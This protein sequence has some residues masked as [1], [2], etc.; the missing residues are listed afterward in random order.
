MSYP[1]WKK[2]HLTKAT[3]EK[4]KL[5][6]DSSYLWAQHDKNLLEK[7]SDEVLA[8]TTASTTSAKSP[9]MPSSANDVNNNKNN[10]HPLMSNVCCQDVEDV[11]VV[12]A[13]PKSSSARLDDAKAT[14]TATP[15]NSKARQAPKFVPPP[16]PT[17]EKLASFSLGILT[18]SDRAS[19]GQYE[20]G[21]LS[22]PAVR[23]SVL[24]FIGGGSETE[25]KTTNSKETQLDPTNIYMSI[26][27]DDINAIQ[28]QLRAW[29]SS[30][31]EDNSAKAL[32][33][34]FTTGG[35]GFSARD[36]TPEATVGVVDYTCEGLVTFCTMECASVQPLA[37]LSRGTAGI[38][39]KTMIVNLPGNPK[40]VQEI[41][42][43][44]LPLCLHVVAD[45]K[46][47]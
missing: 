25:E 12:A 28:D 15:A 7:R 44:L 39:N 13:A 5:Y 26:V 33:L 31:S 3:D 40:G 32:D 41:I 47:E 16:F 2:R 8:T 37:A 43:V 18:V 29:S 4:M 24:S 9:G 10:H 22:G 42:P 36:V 35:T 21:D 17:T 27:P 6:N 11:A 38:K 14:P 30:S 46:H 23:D 19:L 45:L 1:D 34:I 20:S